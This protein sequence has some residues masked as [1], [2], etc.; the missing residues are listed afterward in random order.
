M[1]KN[2]PPSPDAQK[3]STPEKKGL[4]GAMKTFLKEWGIMIAIFGTLYATGLHTEVFGRIQ[5]VILQTGLFSPRVDEE[6]LEAA[7]LRKPAGNLVVQ[8][9]NGDIFHLSDFSGEVVFVNFWATWCPP[10]IAEMPSI[11]ALAKRMQGVEEGDSI[12]FLLVSLDDDPSVALEFAQRKEL[13][14]PIYFLRMKDRRTFDSS[15]I[16]TT[17]VISKKGEVV[18]E[19]RG[20]AKYDTRR[21]QRFLSALAREV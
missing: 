5:Q 18:Y 8:S 19:R 7:G 1:S 17:Y 2:T 15:Q 3:S 9:T 6:D 21:F 14:L 20:M 16:P 12:R 11:E 4:K 13:E 10:C